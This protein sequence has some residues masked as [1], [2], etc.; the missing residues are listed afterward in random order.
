[1]Q[2]RYSIQFTVYQ[3]ETFILLVLIS[4]LLLHCYR[5][6]LVLWYQHERLYMMKAVMIAARHSNRVVFLFQLEHYFPA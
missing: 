3:A 6:A 2:Q 4:F 1:M 5:L